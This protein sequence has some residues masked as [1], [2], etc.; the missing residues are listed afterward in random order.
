MPNNPFKAMSRS[1]S[2]S[3][4]RERPVPPPTEDTAP[5]GLPAPAPP[6]APPRP[7]HT[8]HHT[9]GAK[10]LLLQQVPPVVKQPI[11]TVDSDLELVVSEEVIDIYNDQPL[12]APANVLI[13]NMAS[14]GLYSVQKGDKQNQPLAL[15]SIDDNENMSRLRQ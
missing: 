3:G 6:P 2:A 13:K 7:A 8:F 1:R 9:D 5:P 10:S 4:D 12:K 15:Q 11:A 14:G